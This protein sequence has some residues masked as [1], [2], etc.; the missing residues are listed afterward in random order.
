MDRGREHAIVVGDEV[1]D[2]CTELQ[3]GGEMNCIERSKLDRHERTRCVEYAVA[4]SD[5][6]DTSE[7]SSPR[8]Q[9]CVPPR[10][11][12]PKNLSPGHSA[13]DERAVTSEMPA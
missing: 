10:K 11:E 13:R 9:R 2:V 12:S 8:D 5:E 3:R 1:V 4:D 7:C 6:V